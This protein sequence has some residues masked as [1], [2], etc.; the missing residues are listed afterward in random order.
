MNEEDIADVREGNIW[1]LGGSARL[2]LRAAKN[3]RLTSSQKP[4]FYSQE[5]QK[6]KRTQNLAKK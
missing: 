2:E 3:R 1:Q 4:K 5:F 6:I